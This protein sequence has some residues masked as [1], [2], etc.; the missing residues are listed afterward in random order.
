MQLI[1]DKIEYIIEFKCLNPDFI[2]QI[3]DKDLSMIKIFTDTKNN[4]SKN[5]VT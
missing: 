2:I 3:F 4:L 1:Y 5:T